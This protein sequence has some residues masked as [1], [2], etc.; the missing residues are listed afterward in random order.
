MT[1]NQRRSSAGLRVE[2]GG[3]GM[4]ERAHTRVVAGAYRLNAH[5]APVC[6]PA[7]GGER[8][9]VRKAV[10]TRMQAL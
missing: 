3:V 6:R 10:V 7:V 9:G 4:N 2:R 8:G 1:A 5:L